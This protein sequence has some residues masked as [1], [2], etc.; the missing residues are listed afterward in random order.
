[1]RASTKS[2]L[3]LMSPLVGNWQVAT[4]SFTNIFPLVHL[5]SMTKMTSGLKVC[6][7]EQN[8]KLTRYLNGSS[9]ASA[10]SMK[11]DELAGGPDLIA[12]PRPARR[13]STRARSS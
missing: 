11:D 8:F 9:S 1:M 12:Q 6:N 7:V 5:Q 13:P 3:V 10:K 2:R 4:L